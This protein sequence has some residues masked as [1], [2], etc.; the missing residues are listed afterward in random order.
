MNLKNTPASNLAFLY[1]LG[2]SNLEQRRLVLERQRQEFSRFSLVSVIL[3][4]ALFSLGFLLT[5]PFLLAPAIH[6][7]LIGVV[8]GRFSAFNGIPALFND[9]ENLALNEPLHVVHAQEIGLIQQR[10]NRA[11][12]IASKRNRQ[13]F[14]IRT[15]F[16]LSPVSALVGCVVPI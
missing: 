10:I 3:S 1:Q 2:I 14:L 12:G 16:T 9:P 5:A 4:V 11:I 8:G 7:F 15:A 6:F 13:L